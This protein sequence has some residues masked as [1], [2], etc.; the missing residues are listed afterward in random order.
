MA[1]RANF[2]YERHHMLTPPTEPEPTVISRGVSGITLCQGDTVPTGAGYSPGCIFVH[3]DGSSTDYAYVNNGTVTVADFEKLMDVNNAVALIQA[4]YLA[5]AAAGKGPSPLIWDDAPVLE[6]MLDPTKGF[7]YWDDFCGTDT[8]A[9]T[10]LHNGVL[11]TQNSAGGTVANLAS[12]ASGVLQL[13]APAADEDGPTCQWVGCQVT[14]QAGTT[15]YWEARIKVGTDAEDIFIGLCDDATVNVMNAG[16]IITNKDMAGFFRD[17]GVT[18]AKMGHQVGDGDSVDSADDTIADVDNSAYETFGIK[19]NGVTSVQ[20]YHK[21]AL[22][23]TVTDA[24]DICD[25]LICPVI[26]I[27][28]DGGGTGGSL[29]IDWMRMLAYDADGSCRV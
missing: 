7:Y 11:F 12:V 28:T 19:I 3:M 10:E 16:T 22:V 24:D 18:N 27:T 23:K 8:Y 9:T 13:T 6:V 15:I 17:D 1:N 20:F 14:P 2:W 21:G 4:E 5:T 29:Y 26:Q 25:G